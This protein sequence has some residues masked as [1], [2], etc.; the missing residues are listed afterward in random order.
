MSELRPMKKATIRLFEDDLEYLQHAYANC[1]YN[2]IIRALV[3][4][5]IR[6]LRA[7]T[8]ERLVGKLTP[9]E[10]REV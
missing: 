1:G 6:Q 5:H 7:A 10:L 9:E 3:A 2:K 4:R 8:A